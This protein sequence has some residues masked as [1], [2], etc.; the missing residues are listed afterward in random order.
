MSLN[1]PDFSGKKIYYAGSIRGA[2]EQD[3]ELPWHIV[4]YMADHGAEVLSEHVAARTPEER[5][6]IRATHIGQTIIDTYGRANT[7]EQIRGIDLAWVREADYMVAVV[8]A[9]SLGVGME[10]QYAL[11]KPDLGMQI[12]PILALVHKEFQ[13]QLS[14]MVRGVTEPQFHLYQYETLEDIRAKISWFLTK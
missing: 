5:E 10:L 11:L 13:A 4:R 12:T 1:S 3:Q 8:N 9:P 14:A 2:A 6:A 7:D